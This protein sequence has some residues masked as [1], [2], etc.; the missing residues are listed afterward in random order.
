MNDDHNITLW[1]QKKIQERN[2]PEQY[3]ISADL[4]VEDAKDLY[5]ID[6]RNYFIPSTRLWI[7]FLDVRFTISWIDK[8]ILIQ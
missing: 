3:D 8:D 5:S 2:M 1:L 4:W 7:L 6:D